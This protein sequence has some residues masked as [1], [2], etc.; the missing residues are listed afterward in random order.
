MSTIKCFLLEPIDPEQSRRYV[1]VDDPPR[2][3]RDPDGTVY[4]LGH[5]PID[6][7]L[8]AP[9][10]AM[11]FADWLLNED[12]T[13]R[14]RPG[15]RPPDGHVLVVRVPS[16]LCIGRDWNV[17]GPANNCPGWTRTGTPPNVTARPS[18]GKYLAD[19]SFDYHGWLR[20]G[21][22]VDA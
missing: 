5:R 2:L 6:G 18:I 10:G 17:D 15:H 8:P 22:L 20:N 4:H 9:P 14:S 19:G 16:R 12:G 3:Y 1:S 11:W 13:M 7:V 21:E